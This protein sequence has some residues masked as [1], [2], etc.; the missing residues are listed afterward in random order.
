MTPEQQIIY[1]SQLKRLA[2]IIQKRIADEIQKANFLDIYPSWGDMAIL[3]E[4]E[5][6]FERLSEQIERTTLTF[7]LENIVREL[8]NIEFRLQSDRFEDEHNDIEYYEIALAQH[9]TEINKN[10]PEDT[11]P[12][13]RPW[14]NKQLPDVAGP[15]GGK[16]KKTKRTR[17]NVK[18]SCSSTC[19]SS[20]RRKEKGQKIKEINT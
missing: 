7:D 17:K 18:R 1:V 12:H 3:S 4:L 2:K 16:K 20:R 8:R 9:L 13:L 19:S 14:Q 15:V 5:Q 6:E 10:F 11:M